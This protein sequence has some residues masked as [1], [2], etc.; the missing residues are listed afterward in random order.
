MAEKLAPSSGQFVLVIENVGPSSYFSGMRQRAA[1][2]ELRASIVAI[3]PAPT[4]LAANELGFVGRS[5]VR[6]FDHSATMS[7][8][9]WSHS[10]VLAREPGVNAET[11]QAPVS[12]HRAPQKDSDWGLDGRQGRGPFMLHIAI[13][14]GRRGARNSLLSPSRFLNEL[15]QRPRQFATLIGAVLA[16][17]SG[18]LF[19]NVA[20]PPFREV[21]RTG[22]LYWPSNKSWMTASRSVSSTLVSRQA[23]PMRPKSSSTRKTSRSM[24]G[25]YRG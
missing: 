8:S 18:Y 20:N 25:D 9:F 21:T 7:R 16:Q 19:G 10:L 5:G 6:V 17:S 3:N 11:W 2:L 15:I 22:L 1:M 12:L 23:Q 14:R 24:P 4:N 13:W